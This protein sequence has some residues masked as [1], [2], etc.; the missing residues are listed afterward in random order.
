MTS[1]PSETTARAETW[2]W[3]VVSA[4][5]VA[6]IAVQT[7][8]ATALYGVPIA[9]AFTLTVLHA[10]ALP[11]T[12]RW[13]VVAAVLSVVAAF[14]LQWLT[15][16]IPSAPWPWTVTAEIM[17]FFVVFLLALR[18]VW[19]VATATLLASVAG[20]TAVAF[21]HGAGLADTA[22]VD[23]IVFVS[24]G[25]GV[26]GIGI[27]VRQWRRIR[28]QL[29]R[30]QRISAEELSRRVVAEERTRLARDLHDVIAHSMSVISVQAA[31]A[32][33]RLGGV[34]PRTAEEFADNA[35]QARTALRE[36]RV[37]LG[38]LRDD[39]AAPVEPQR[40]IADIAVLLRQTAQA[41][42]DVHL[43]WQGPRSPRLTAVADLAAYRVVQE[44][45]SNALRHAPG[46]PIRVTVDV[47]ERGL[48]IRVR[49][50]PGSSPATD[51]AGGGHG[52]VAMSERV[53]SAGGVVHAHPTADGGFEVAAEF[54]FTGEEESPA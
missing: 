3:I 14:T 23:N 36:M 38:A 45:V 13:P 29:V 40:G 20:S 1:Q 31:S 19:Q 10:G 46:S 11:L 18:T 28:V 17:Q 32:P 30:E 25:A 26:L 5:A 53:R 21:A 37:L 47:G 2:L 41:G 7:P 43:D 50:A 52:L 39:E 24:I 4:V 33:A 15:P 22:A 49:N 44:A 16:P 51:V 27:T 6:M 9:L 48:G 42:A 35:A 34:E 54:E 8:I 12:L